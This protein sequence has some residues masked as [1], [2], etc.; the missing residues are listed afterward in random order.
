MLSPRIIDHIVYAVPDLERAMSQLEDQLGIRPVFGGF[1]KTQGTKNALL[2]LG[3]GCY[4]E[5]LAIDEEN[6]EING[7]RWMG[8]DL[9][10][11]PRVTRWAIKSETIKQDS[12][13]LKSYDSKMGEIYQGSRKTTAGETLAWKMILPL[14]SPKIELMPFMVD[15][16]G[17]AF[18]PT[19]KLEDICSIKEISFVGNSPNTSNEVFNKLNI[20]TFISKA[21]K[22]MI[23]V[24]IKGP[25]G[26]VVL[27]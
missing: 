17:S 15:W 27:F 9:I 26:I 1:H 20:S 21:E 5:I 23:S 12:E 24:T 18:H 19:E 16:S 13:T 10:T 6:T 14:P 7:P 8:I 2:N 22:D 11:E 25:S 4:L 3:A